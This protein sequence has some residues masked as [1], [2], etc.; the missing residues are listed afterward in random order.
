MA[1]GMQG[2]GLWAELSLIDLSGKLN[3][4]AKIDPTTGQLTLAGLGDEVFG[5]IT[6]AAT[7]GYSSTIQYSDVG[8]I[9]LG[10]TLSAWTRVVSDANGHAVALTSSPPNQRVAGII[11]RGGN[12]G[13]VVPILLDRA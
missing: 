12:S 13:E 4:F 3:C 11:I 7:Q 6:E 9:I 10:A 1:T 5:C 2:V 8:K